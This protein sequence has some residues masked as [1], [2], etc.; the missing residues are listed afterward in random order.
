MHEWKGHLEI[1]SRPQ[2][3][4]NSR[5]YM[6]PPTDILQKTVVGWV[7]LY[8]AKLQV[9]FQSGRKYIQQFFQGTCS[10]NKPGR[11]I[12]QV[13]LWSVYFDNEV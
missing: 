1:L 9:S 8:S 12:K 6:L 2:D 13:S 3:T 7:P 10:R 11:S 4:E 5:Q